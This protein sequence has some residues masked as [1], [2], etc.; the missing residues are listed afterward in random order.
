M[1]RVGAQHELRSLR[2]CD[3]PWYPWRELHPRTWLERPESW[4]LDDTDMK[5]NAEGGGVEPHP[6]E[7]TIRLA[8]GARAT[9][10][11][12]SKTLPAEESQPPREAPKAR[13]PRES[14]K[15]RAKRGEDAQR[16]RHPQGAA[17]G[18]PHPCEGT[19]RLA[20]GARATAS[21]PSTHSRKRR[22]RIGVEDGSFAPFRELRTSRSY[23]APC[24]VYGSGHA[25]SS[26]R[27][28]ARR[29]L[30]ERACCFAN[31]VTGGSLP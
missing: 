12:P 15:P 31:S 20:P 29:L 13:S 7:G 17:C 3:R 4:L 23:R 18:E 14:P 8:P 19:I 11:S 26:G 21:S 2:R 28:V 24:G 1:G 6:C 22:T 16:T 25:M 27:S 30:D 9:A 5:R 10:S